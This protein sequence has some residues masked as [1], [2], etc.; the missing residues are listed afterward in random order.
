M[1]ISLFESFGLAT[2]YD[3]MMLS[4]HCLRLTSYTNEV[5]R[6]LSTAQDCMLHSHR[7]APGSLGS[8]TELREKFGPSLVRALKWAVY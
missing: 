6:T 1:R 3:N 5:H 4:T 7:G 8:A 2:Y